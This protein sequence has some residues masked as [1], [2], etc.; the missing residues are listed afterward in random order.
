MIEKCAERITDWLIENDAI[1]NA[2]K[3]VYVYGA[4]SLILSALPL[5]MALSFGLLMG[6]P[7]RA[8]LIIMPFV[9]VRKYSGGFHTRKAWT[10]ILGSSLLL[11]LCIPLSFALTCTAVLAFLSVIAAVSLILFSPIDNKNRILEVSEKKHCKKI[12]AVWSLYY[13]LVIF[14]CE[15]GGQTDTAA[16]VTVGMVLSAGLQYPYLIKKVSWKTPKKN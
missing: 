7:I 2:D 12:T 15:I 16:C 11:V 1:K 14:I 9:L 4:Y 8:M 3:D 6:C 5:I 10:C 13:L